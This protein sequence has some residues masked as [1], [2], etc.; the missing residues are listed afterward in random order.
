MPQ[1]TKPVELAVAPL[2][3]GADVKGWIAV[4]HPPDRSDHFTDHRMLLLAG[5]ASH[6]SMALQKALAYKDQKESAEIAN[7]LLRFGRELATAEGATEVLERVVELSAGMLG[8]P[9]SMVWLSDLGT[10]E[11]VVKASYGYHGQSLQ[12]IERSRLDRRT[13]S[14]FV[15]LTEPFVIGAG[16]LS[17]VPGAAILNAGAP[18][19][20]AP[21]RLEGGRMGWIVAGA[22]ALGDYEFSER[23]MRLL[24]G[25]A[26]QTS[27]AI[28]NAF[29]FE[30][31]EQTFLDTVE[32][33]A[34]A[35]EAKDEYTS[36]HA[37]WIRDT[38]VEV[39]RSLGMD[40]GALKRLELGALFHD[41]GKIGIPSDILRKP[42]PLDDDEWAIIRMHPE[43][44]ERILGPIARLADVRPIVRHC[45]EHWDGSGY[46]DK[47]SGDDIPIESRI[48]L[49]VDAFH[50]MTTDRPYRKA[51]PIE[52]ARSRLERSSGTQFDPCVVNAFGR[53]IEDNPRLAKTA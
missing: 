5:L 1:G 45:H 48:I 12:R 40:A 36:S 38:A 7:S 16:G 19:A 51:M 33:L 52:E 37:Q 31:L 4:R 6:A 10:G 30:S 23:K 47:K 34:N 35:L 43:L 11:A 15:E 46:P 18:A 39:G 22:P 26:H 20:V 9:H 50:A 53:L 41:I 25:I 27:L 17:D 29:S 44:G 21:L 13:A 28:N 49:V 32:S 8:S 3:L 24:E 42:G 2:D 14:G